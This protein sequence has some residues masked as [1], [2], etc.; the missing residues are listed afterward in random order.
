[1]GKTVLFGG[2]FHE[3]HTFLRQPTTVADFE[4]MAV[5]IGQAAI[6]ENLGNASPSDGFLSHAL[7]QGWTVVPTIQMAAMPGGK[8]E[9]AAVELFRRNFLPVLEAR[10][11]ELDGI[12]LV[13]HGAMVSAG[14]DDPEGD[15]LRDIRAVLDSRG[16]DIPLVGVLDLHA[17]VSQTMID[18]SSALI[19]YRENPHK[20]ARDTAVRAARLFG[21]LMDE[22]K[23]AQVHRPTRYVLPPTGVGSADDPMKAVLAAARAI[24]ARDPDMLNINVM[25]GYSYADVPDCGFSLSAATTGDPQR[26]A[27]YL[28]DLVAVLEANIAKGYPQD[29]PLADVLKLVD[30]LPPGKGPI[31][32]IEPADNIGGGTPGDA[33]DLLGPLLATGRGGIVAAIA[34]PEAVA[35][36]RKAGAGATVSLT[37]GGKTDEHHGAPLPFSGTV[38]SLS[39][40]HFELELKTSHLASMLGS[41][42]D[43]G[44][45]AVV[46]NAQAIILVSS[47]KMPPMDLGQLHSQGVRPEEAQYVVVKAAVSHRD[48]YDP[49]ARASFYVV[50]AGLCTSNLRRLPY[51]KLAGKIVGLP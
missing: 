24:E 28:E 26:A 2:L 12:F 34:D 21:R 41:E 29:R 7:E 33:T 49:I 32:L 14:S 4:A 3:T 20:D 42:A 27:A 46:E 10:L 5:H 16:V 40:G 19:A 38:R 17:N 35:Q 25:A 51:R 50:S 36:C 45:C 22:P 9:D 8:V 18:Y 48:A 1:V 43:M 47:R 15:L 30:A 44:P 31:L 39:D 13:L 37:I 23:I 6:D 11:G